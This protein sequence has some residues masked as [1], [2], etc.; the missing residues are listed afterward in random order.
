M[1]ATVRN[2]EGLNLEASKLNVDAG[3]SDTAAYRRYK[4]HETDEAAVDMLRL[5]PKQLILGV[6]L[7]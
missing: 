7:K 3:P 4:K 6:F 5:L 2:I 1:K